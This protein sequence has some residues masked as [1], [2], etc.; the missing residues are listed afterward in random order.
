MPRK[1]AKQIVDEVVAKVK[2]EAP[3]VKAK[4]PEVE[5]A[6]AP[7]VE[8]YF[9]CMTIIAPGSKCNCYAFN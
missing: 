3:K 6:K 7:E 2:E 4:A 8:H 9:R 5:E 1:S